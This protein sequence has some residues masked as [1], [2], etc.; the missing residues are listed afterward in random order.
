MA[1]PAQAPAAAVAVT[2]SA[3]SKKK[4]QS[5]GGEHLPQFFPSSSSVFH[6][7]PLIVEAGVVRSS[8]DGVNR[9]TDLKDGINPSKHIIKMKQQLINILP[10]ILSQSIKQYLNQ[11]MLA[12]KFLSTSFCQRQST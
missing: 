6:E 10:V 2:G 5:A 4:K 11:Y 7:L 8:V 9:R 3:A 1:P 12:S